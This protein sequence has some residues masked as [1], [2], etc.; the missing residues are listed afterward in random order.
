MNVKTETLLVALFDL[1]CIEN[2]E[3]MLNL[4][5]VDPHPVS[6]P[7]DVCQAQPPWNA[8]SLPVQVLNLTKIFGKIAPK[9]FTPNGQYFHGF[10]ISMTFFKS[11]KRRIVFSHQRLIEAA[12]ERHDLSARSFDP[13]K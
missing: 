6:L 10:V 13:P 2:V 9:L 4:G 1:C 3:K 11:V 5:R 12:K 8:N 7:A